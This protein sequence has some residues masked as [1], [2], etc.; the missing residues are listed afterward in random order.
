MAKRS[1]LE[2][3]S[4]LGLIDDIG[5]NSKPNF[6]IIEK[7]LDHATLL[8]EIKGFS[9]SQHIFLVPPDDEFPVFVKR[10]KPGE[11][12][13]GS[14]G[15]RLWEGCGE[16]QMDGLELTC[17]PKRHL[18]MAQRD[19]CLTHKFEGVLFVTLKVDAGQSTNLEK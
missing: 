19:L 1:N 4:R 9:Y 5:V 6:L 14:A 18:R 16:S 3:T 7:Q 12:A 11:I 17:W 13:N 8:H 10:R 2:L 15:V